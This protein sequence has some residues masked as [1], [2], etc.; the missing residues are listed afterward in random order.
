MARNWKLTL[1]IALF[2]LLGLLAA[3]YLRGFVGQSVLEF[4]PEIDLATTT[5]NPGYVGA[6]ACAECH[7]TRVHEFEKTRHFLAA[8][9]PTPRVMPTGFLPGKGRFSSDEPSL[10]FENVRQDET[11]VQIAVRKE[12]QEESRAVAPI[13]FVYGGAGKFDEIYFT[14]HEDRLFELPIAWLHPFN[15]WGAAPFDRGA[16]GDCS[17]PTQPRCLECHFTWFEHIHGT[18]NRYKPDSFLFGVTC[19]RCHGPGKDHVDHHK[20]NPGIKTPHAISHPGTF[21]RDRQIDVCIQCHNNAPKGRG[22]AMRFR[23]GETAE[24][25]FRTNLSTTPETDHVGNQIRYM[26][27]SKCYQ[28]SDTLTCVSCHNPHRVEGEAN[29]GSVRNTCLKCH[30]SSACKDQKNLPPE[31]Q[32]KCHACHMPGKFKIQVTFDTEDERHVPPVRV[33]EHR[34]GV[35]P[36]ARQEVLFDWIRQQKDAKS[37][38]EADSLRESLTKH[39][40]DEAESMRK[41]HRFLAAVAACREAYRIHPSKEVQKQLQA[42]VALHAQI[43]EDMSRASKYVSARRFNDAIPLLKKVLEVKPN[44]AFVHGKL[45]TAY[46]SLGQETLATQ[47]LS[48]VA[49]YDPDDPY[50]WNMLGWNALMKNDFGRAAEY[51]EKACAIDPANDVLTSRWGMALLKLERWHDAEL[52]FRQTIELDPNHVGALH[53]LAHS[54]VAQDRAKEAIGYATRAVRLSEEM[55]PDIL[56]TLGRAYE[57]T[58]RLP[59]ALVLASKARKIAEDRMPA[60]VPQIDQQVESWKAAAVNRK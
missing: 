4:E 23:P 36:A 15:R 26:R 41:Q 35:Y 33:A 48:V 25:Y 30:Q 1:G 21:H 58:N 17:R 43:E 54:L 31:V 45:G 40:L 55:N 27:E 42:T 3:V 16:P 56:L 57:Q 29:S 28:N 5:P 32:Q 34:I 10:Y 52:K 47:H 24:R 2:A 14:W 11:Y 39:W 44:H 22:H 38:K 20:S 6:A 51:Y 7:Q 60:V 12:S 50:G 13:A 49:K 59:H 46:L 8:I 37:K 53:G 9:K 19:E 18:E